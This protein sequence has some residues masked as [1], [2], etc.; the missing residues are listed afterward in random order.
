MNLN[1]EIEISKAEHEKGCFKYSLL[2]IA[3]NRSIENSNINKRANNEEYL[4]FYAACKAGRRPYG[5]TV[6][7]SIKEMT[8]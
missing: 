6:V 3:L 5:G 4:L 2:G 8:L 1:C 7:D